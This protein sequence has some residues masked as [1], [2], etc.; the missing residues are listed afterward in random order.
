M[1]S[2]NLVSHGDYLDSKWLI[3]MGW[4]I[5]EN[6]LH[7]V[8]GQRWQRSLVRE[9]VGNRLGTGMKETQTSVYISLLA[10]RSAN[11][12]TRF[13]KSS[14]GLLAAATVYATEWNTRELPFIVYVA[15]GHFV[16]IEALMATAVI[17][18][19]RDHYSFQHLLSYDEQALAKKEKLEDK[20]REGRS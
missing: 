9:Q 14:G 13:G 1:T 2:I 12:D 3:S 19:A 6:V 11:M 10:R 8:G 20:I 18:H 4:Q 7:G 5:T 15:G 16:A 17:G